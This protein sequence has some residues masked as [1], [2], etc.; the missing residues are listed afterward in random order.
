M[1]LRIA[2]GR[3]GGNLLMATCNMFR[4]T[5]HDWTLVSICMICR[6]VHWTASGCLECSQEERSA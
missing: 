3:C 6:A 5:G 1:E 2:C 4:G